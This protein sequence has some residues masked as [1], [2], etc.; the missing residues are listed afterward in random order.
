MKLYYVD[1]QQNKQYLRIDTKNDNNVELVQEQEFGK[2]SA[3]L[4]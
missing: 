4:V 2:V 3:F 1:K